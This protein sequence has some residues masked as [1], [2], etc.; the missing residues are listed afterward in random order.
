MFIVFIHTVQAFNLFYC[1]FDYIFWH[2]HKI[3]N[4]LQCLSLPSLFVLERSSS[5]SFFS[6]TGSVWPFFYLIIQK[7]DSISN[8]DTCTSSANVSFFWK[9]FYPVR[10]FIVYLHSLVFPVFHNFLIVYLL[11][12]RT[13]LRFTVSPFFEHLFHHTLFIELIF[14]CTIFEKVIHIHPA[15][16]L[17][18]QIFFV[19][20]Q[21]NFCLFWRCY[22][23]R[24]FCVGKFL[25]KDLFSS[26]FS[27]IR[28]C[29]TVSLTVKLLVSLPSPPGIASALSS[30][31]YTVCA[32]CTLRL[33][34]CL[35]TVMFS[36][37]WLDLIVRLLHSVGSK[38]N[39]TFPFF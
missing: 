6:N 23:Y 8:W 27:F 32:F 15:S 17:F 13:S 19:L 24:H 30:P 31:L 38:L 1:C 3:L 18:I 36:F 25:D 26:F 29:F 12:S 7:E 28:F 39:V 22:P 20:H 4:H 37:V 2:L 16:S 5:L 14:I 11:F 9:L 21:T 34:S 35:Y 10:V 33:F